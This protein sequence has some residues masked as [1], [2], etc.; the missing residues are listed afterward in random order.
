MSTTAPTV[1]LADDHQLFLQGLAGLLQQGG[2]RIAGMAT[3]GAEAE[4]LARRHRPDIAL[5]DLHMPPPNGLELGARLKQEALVQG[6]LI[7]TMH[8]SPSLL[9]RVKA[10][11]LDGYLLKNTGAE[12]LLAA[13]ASVRA[14]GTWFPA[15]PA[16]E[17]VAHG[18]SELTARELDVLRGVAQGLTS[19]QLAE[20][21]GI[22]LR[23]VDTHRK[24][25][26][27]KLGTSQVS[28]WVV[29]AQ[30]LGLV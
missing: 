2:Y 13:L 8:H 23:T 17:R 22:A 19:A 1:L 15:M 5:L 30:R 25:I 11:G 3:T 16:S 28:E 6:V 21:L 18:G 27:S 20:R 7:V 10:L 29:R 26:S 12:E 14:G 24:N 4:A 9:R